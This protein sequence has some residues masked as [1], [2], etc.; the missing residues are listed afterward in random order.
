MRTSAGSLGTAL[1]DPLGMV[2]ADAAPAVEETGVGSVA[3]RGPAVTDG[4]G[5]GV[6]QAPSESATIAS[7][8]ANAA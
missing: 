4:G 6:A 3:V 5:D 1:V 2:V 7:V 8:P